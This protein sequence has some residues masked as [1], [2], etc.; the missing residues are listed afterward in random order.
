MKRRMVSVMYEGFAEGREFRFREGLPLA[1]RVLH[2]NKSATDEAGALH[3]HAEAAGHGA[4][5]AGV[6]DTKRNIVRA[7]EALV[8]IDGGAERIIAPHD[9]E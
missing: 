8:Q 6:F 3:V 4:G 9:G 7:K 1:V 2:F 5:S